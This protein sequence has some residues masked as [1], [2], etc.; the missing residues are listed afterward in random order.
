VKNRAARHREKPVFC[1]RDA[2]RAWR[3]RVSHPEIRLPDA[4]QKL[5]IFFRCDADRRVLDARM[6]HA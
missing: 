2:L 6:G 3:F 1:S 5:A 4:R